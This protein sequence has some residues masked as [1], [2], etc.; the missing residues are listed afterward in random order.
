M[1]DYKVVVMGCSAGGMHALETILTPL[2]KSYPLPIIVVQHIGATANNYLA[3]YLNKLCAI[4]VQEA[5]EKRRLQAGVVCVAPPNYH[6]L[7]EKDATLSL[8]IDARVH[9]ARPSIDVLFESAADAYASH[10]IGLLLT[11]G[12]EDG[13]RGLKSIKN[14]G[15]WTVVQEPATAEIPIMP[16]AAI[17]LQAA[18]QVVPLEELSDLLQS[19]AN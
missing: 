3:R 9:F 18:H 4:T 15:G 1:S 16:M 17:D 10:V 2:P 6:L 11:G 13:A 8:S 19:L 5:R 14:T 7:V 12:N